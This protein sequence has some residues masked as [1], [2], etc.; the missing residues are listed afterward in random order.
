[1]GFPS[2]TNKIIIRRLERSTFLVKLW[3]HKGLTPGLNRKNGIGSRSKRQIERGVMKRCV[4][5]NFVVR[6]VSINIVNTGKRACAEGVSEQLAVEASDRVV[7]PY[8]EEAEGRI[9]KL[10]YLNLNLD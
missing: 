1:M 4:Y 10:R 6:A 7:G 9:K 5:D 8:R 3:S 2:K